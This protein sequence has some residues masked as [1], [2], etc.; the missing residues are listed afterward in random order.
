MFKKYVER[1]E[2]EVTSVW[3]EVEDE[4]QEENVF[5]QKVEVNN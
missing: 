4:I 5:L 2:G 3:M 1:N